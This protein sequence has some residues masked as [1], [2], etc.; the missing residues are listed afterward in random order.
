MSVN[1]KAHVIKL[2]EN[3]SERERQIALLHYEIRCAA[4]VSPEE[5]IGSMSLGNSDGIGGGSSRGH[6]SNKTMYIALNY[7]ERMDDLK[8]ESINEIVVRLMKLEEEQDRIRYYMSLLEKREAEVLRLFYIEQKTTEAIQ[9]TM[10]HSAKTL[11]KLRDQA[12][13]TLAEMYE[14]S[15]NNQ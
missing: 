14:F 13:N 7:Q 6:I 8:A 11:R 2:L 9:K 3:Y 4:S 5:V 15:V 12:V 10:K 1:M